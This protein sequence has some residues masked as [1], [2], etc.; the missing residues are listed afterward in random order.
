MPIHH[1][2][3]AEITL[4]SAGL[5]LSG[6]DTAIIIGGT[7]E[8]TPSTAFA[9]TA[10]ELYLHPLGF[11]GGATGSAVCDMSGT[12]PCTAPLQV[13]T[14]PELGEEGPST[15]VDENDIV[16]AVEAEFAATPNAFSAEDP[17]TVFAYSQGAM[18]ASAAMT[19]LANDGIPLQD[20]H[21]VFIGDPSDPAGIAVNINADLDHLL[22]TTIASALLKAVDEDQFGVGGSLVGVTPDDLFPTT[23]YTI[24]GDGVADWQTDWNAAGGGLSGLS[25]A[26][27]HFAVTHLEYMGLTPAEVATGVTTTDGQITNIA[28]PDTFN[29]GQAW[30]DAFGNGIAN[31]GLW[32]SLATT[33]QDILDGQY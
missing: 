8:P 23:N 19:Q 4:L 24:D 12:D 1:T 10:E 13:L 33:L 28:I 32:Q 18:A 20:V 9:Q 17:L 7:F 29:D 16:K 31:S 30:T 14:T 11:D 15:L 21:F 25:S 22:G 2:V 6:S 3:G 27:E 26:L 5:P